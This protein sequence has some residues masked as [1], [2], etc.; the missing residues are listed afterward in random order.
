M[1][2]TKGTTNKTPTQLRAEAERLKR[3]AKL[4]EDLEKLKAKEPVTSS[5]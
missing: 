5:R 1:A 3:K 4:L 2:R